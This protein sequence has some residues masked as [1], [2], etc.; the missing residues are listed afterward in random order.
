VRLAVLLIA[1]GA[2]LIVVVAV[3]G[4]SDDKSQEGEP[5][6]TPL[7]TT[8]FVPAGTRGED[9]EWRRWDEW[10]EPAVG[11]P[12]PEWAVVD[13]VYIDGLVTAVDIPSD[14]FLREE[15]FVWKGS[16]G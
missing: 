3:H 1:L 9:V 4:M 12:W 6:P 2:A 5:V 7:V 16:S 10:P 13:P 11:L 15:W 14:S 8:Q